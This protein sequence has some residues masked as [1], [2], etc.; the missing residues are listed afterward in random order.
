MRYAKLTSFFLDSALNLH[1][2]IEVDLPGIR[3]AR[4]LEAVRASRS[5]AGLSPIT[6]S[7]WAITEK[8]KM[9]NS[10]L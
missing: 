4:E 9:A 7:T 8:Y 10:A 3:E 5:P 2:W 1:C 6:Y